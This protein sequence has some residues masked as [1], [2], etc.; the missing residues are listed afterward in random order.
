M[1]VPGETGTPIVV[2]T[3]HGRIGGVEVGVGVSGAGQ[4]QSRPDP[5]NI[6]IIY[7]PLGNPPKEFIE[8]FGSSYKYGS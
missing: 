6:R 8:F 7:G 2:T 5:E 4:I 1:A 3:G